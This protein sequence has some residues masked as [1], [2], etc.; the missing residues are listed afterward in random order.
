LK[1]ENILYAYIAITPP[2]IILLYLY[3]KNTAYINYW[4]TAAAAGIFALLSLAVYAAIA[5]IGKPSGGRAA[6]LTVVLWVLSVAVR[7]LYQV[8]FMLAVLKPVRYGI[9]LL[10]ILSV[11]AAVF[12]YGKRIRRKEV[13][14]LTAVFESVLLLLNFIP[15][16]I[17]FAAGG[18]ERGTSVTIKT[19]D[20]TVNPTSPSPNIYWLFMDGM[21]G[22]KGMETLFDD[23]QS[24][25][26]AEL[27]ER[28]FR[29]NRAA[30][31]EVV[32]GTVRATP[33]LFCPVW[34][35]TK[36]FPLLETVDLG[37]YEEKRR[38]IGNFNTISGRVNNEFITAFNAKGYMT[39][40]VSDSGLHLANMFLATIKKPFVDN[41]LI[42]LK[43]PNLLFSYIQMVYL[44]NLLGNS[45]APYFVTRSLWG[46]LINLIYV[47]V[48]NTGF[49]S[50]PHRDK[51]AIYG[52]AYSMSDVWYAG[53][54]MEIFAEKTEPRLVIVHEVKAHFPFRLDENGSEVGARSKAE[55]LNPSRYPPQHRYAA[56]FLVAYIDF[57]LKNDPDAVIVVQAD[58]G[59]HD[60]KTRAMLLA[61]GKTE[62]DVRVMQNSVISAV[63]IPERWGGLDKPIDP[64]NISRVLINRYVGKNYAL[65]ETHP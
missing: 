44:H 10:I 6:L 5:Q 26:T 36:F 2:F 22:F 58:H 29:I 55:G 4:H 50:V 20:F 7:A 17:R 56:R 9:N 28:G 39:Y 65:L 57:I 60:E 45:I 46:K 18:G 48:E 43:Q 61:A 15:A 19:S 33:A 11:V 52:E 27:E 14:V 25:F 41:E 30:E 13:F 63:R 34:Y 3:T 35:D 54:L 64:L 24:A 40:T 21:L 51:T 53:A 42:S 38:K 12:M 32:H 49:I 16:T 23:R 37:N 8:L 31:F 62:D 59:L 1:K 47:N